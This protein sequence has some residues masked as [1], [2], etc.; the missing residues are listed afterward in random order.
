MLKTNYSNEESSASL[1]LSSGKLEIPF[2][3]CDP[4]ND[5]LQSLVCISIVSM[6]IV[7]SLV[8]CK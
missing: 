4:G 7:H 6:Y 3:K 8:N 1:Y 2:F 5:G